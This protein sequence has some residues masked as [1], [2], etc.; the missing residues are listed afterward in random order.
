MP[1]LGLE[2]LILGQQSHVGLQ[3]IERYRVT[4]LTHEQ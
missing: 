1:A 2:T 3:H 4:W